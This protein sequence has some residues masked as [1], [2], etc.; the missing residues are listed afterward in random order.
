MSWAAATA[1]SF[2]TPTCR[3][4]LAR[5]LIIQ[6]FRTLMSNSN[7]YCYLME[8]WLLS[9]LYIDC[10]VLTSVRA[11]S[12]MHRHIPD[13]I[14]HLARNG[15]ASMSVNQ[16]ASQLSSAEKRSETDRQ[17]GNYTYCNVC[18]QISFGLST[19]REP[20]SNSHW[21]SCVICIWVR[22]AIFYSVHSLID[23]NV[24]LYV[25]FA[26]GTNIAIF[27]TIHA[28]NTLRLG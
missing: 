13:L 17:L 12:I 6:V 3:L 21:D 10:T 23:E 5:I 15:V 8:P 7:T 22:L 24:H 16:L 28:S 14:E 20:L 27:A 11:C 2:G 1:K 9:V 4:A 18:T 19:P 26:F 25:I